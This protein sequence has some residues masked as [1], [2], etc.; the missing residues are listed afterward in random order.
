[1]SDENVSGRGDIVHVPAQYFD[2]GSGRKDGHERVARRRLC[3]S[4]SY[5]KVKVWYLLMIR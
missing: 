3:K 4:T 1:M 5:M 2:I